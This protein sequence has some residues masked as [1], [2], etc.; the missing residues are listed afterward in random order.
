M[1]DVTGGQQALADR[2]RF[3]VSAA[4]RWINEMRA[5]VL[6]LVL[7][8][9]SS[10]SRSPRPGDRSLNYTEQT[11][12]DPVV[13]HGP[14]S[15]PLGTRPDPTAPPPSEEPK[16]DRFVGP[17]ECLQKNLTRASCDL[18]FCPPWQRCV[19]GRCSCKPPYMCPVRGED[20][21]CGLDHRTYRSYCQEGGACRQ[22]GGACRQ[23]GGAYRQEGG[24]CRQEGG[25]CRQE[26]GALGPL[27][28]RVFQVMALSCLKKR[29]AM[30]HFGGRCEER[31]PKFSSS[32]DAASGVV[33]LFLPDAGE[34]EE[35]LV[36]WNKL[37][38]MAAANVACRNETNRLE[39]GPLRNA[40]VGR[41]PAPP[42][43]QVTGSSIGPPPQTDERTRS[44]DAAANAGLH[45]LRSRVSIERYLI[46]AAAIAL[47]REEEREGARERDEVRGEKREGLEEGERTDR[48]CLIVDC[49]VGT[50]EQRDSY[51][52]NT[53]R[54]VAA[55]GTVTVRAIPSV[56]DLVTIVTSVQQTRRPDIGSRVTLTT[57][58]LKPFPSITVMRLG[59]FCIFNL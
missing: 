33:R 15:P 43:P 31:R 39:A 55:V 41:G 20:T 42:P 50:N 25:A 23:E 59:I 32:V 8:V 10:D 3:S 28:R 40:S 38:N 24:A 56:P 16:K 44:A 35:L 49:G 1:G 5:S 13:P 2:T 53:D 30:S 6:L 9:L 29:A 34:G 57:T 51:P 22:E 45:P 48:W 47:I 46:A 12:H 18:V 58:F 26:G 52:V 11:A 54:S 17:A 21:V 7:L 4:E 37:W 14:P 27:S 36:C 19:E